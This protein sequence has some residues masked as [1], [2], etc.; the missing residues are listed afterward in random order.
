MVRWGQGS[1]FLRPAQK[2]GVKGGG[3]EEEK[4]GE[5]DGA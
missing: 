2:M 3:I 4:G 1:P 5:G